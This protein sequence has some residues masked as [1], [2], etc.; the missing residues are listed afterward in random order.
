MAFWVA[1]LA[2]EIARET[3][4]L[5]MD[6]PPESNANFQLFRYGDYARAEGRWRRIDGGEEL[7][8]TAVTIQCGNDIGGCIEAT[9]KGDDQFYYAPFVDHFTAK[10]EDSAITY[11]NDSAT[12]VK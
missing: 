9:V 8:D 2:F 11:E 6:S 5:A 4:V 7:L 10:F 1:L 12:C 3:A